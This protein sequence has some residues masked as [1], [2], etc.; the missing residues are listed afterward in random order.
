[1]PSTDMHLSA[2]LIEDVA[3]TLGVEHTVLPDHSGRG[4]RGETCAAVVLPDTRQ[5]HMFVAQLALVLDERGRD[6][7]PYIERLHLD[8]FGTDVVLELRGVALTDRQPA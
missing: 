6:I 4:M 1:M 7:F 8:S 2:D 5:T 3:D